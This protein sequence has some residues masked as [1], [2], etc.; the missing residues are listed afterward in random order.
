MQQTQPSTMKY[1]GA[2]LLAGFTSSFC[3]HSLLK[4][5]LLL[6]SQISF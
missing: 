3:M 5:S 4:Q 1:I 6:K 2:W